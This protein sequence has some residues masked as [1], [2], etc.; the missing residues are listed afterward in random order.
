MVINEALKAV[1]GLL[2]ADSL[3]GGS[4]YV[5]ADDIQNFIPMNMLRHGRCQPF[6]QNKLLT[7]L[8]G[9][10]DVSHPNFLLDQFDQ[11][12]KKNEFFPQSEGNK[13]GER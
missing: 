9:K 13:G 6:F 2:F 10:G 5:Q 7:Y 12:M 4:F 8:R 1:L 11:K 3:F